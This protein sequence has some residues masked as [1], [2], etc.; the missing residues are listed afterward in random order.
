V[1]AGRKVAY[2]GI[3]AGLT[4]VGAWIRVPLWPVPFTLQVFFVLLSGALLGPGWGALSQVVYLG[5]IFAGLPLSASGGGLGAII[6]P[7]F[8]YL[9]GFPAAAGITGALR[10]KGFGRTW[11]AMFAGLGLIYLMG[12][13]YLGF[14][15]RHIA[16]APRSLPDLLRLGFLP[17]L[18][19]DVAKV[20]LASYVVVRLDRYMP[21]WRSSLTAVE[22]EG[23]A[24]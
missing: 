13:S 23:C 15:F 2:V 19:G 7:T 21:K 22:E 12:V 6:S 14:Y 4:G 10:G 8:G 18:P 1:N 11:L 17:F 9:L 24:S 3:M 16:H 5:L 20:L